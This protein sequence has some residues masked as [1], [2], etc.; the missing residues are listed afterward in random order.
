MICCRSG[1]RKSR[2]KCR[3]ETELSDT[4]LYS[5]N[6]KRFAELMAQIETHCAPKRM[7]LRNAGWTLAEMVEHPFP[8]RRS[9]T[10]RPAPPISTSS[11]AAPLQRVIPATAIEHVVTVA[12]VEIILAEIA[13]H[14][15]HAIPAEQA[16]VAIRA[17]NIVIAAG[18]I[19][20][21]FSWAE[22]T[23]AQHRKE[24]R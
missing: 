15:V 11:P 12:A 10:S 5:R 3:A 1:S 6:P 9:S 22:L 23:I 14:M 20:H 17:E 8:R 13:E 19:V 24:R 2:R 16:I 4:H 7:P 18:Q 21:P